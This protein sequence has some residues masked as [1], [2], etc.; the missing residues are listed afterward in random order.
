MYTT[1]RTMVSVCNLLYPI[2]IWVVA[3]LNNYPVYIAIISSSVFMLNVGVYITARVKALES[4]DG[5]LYV[6]PDESETHLLVEL[7][8]N[9]DKIANQNSVVFK[10]ENG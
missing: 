4:K 10:V 8:R 2:L 6:I 9:V 5:T 1:I 3:V 7:N